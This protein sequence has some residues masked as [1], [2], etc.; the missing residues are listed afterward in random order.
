MDIPPDLRDACRALGQSRPTLWPQDPCSRAQRQAL[1]RCLIDQVVLD[2]RAPETMATRMVW[3]GGAV[4][5]LG[6]PCPVGRL[7][8]WRDVRQLEAQMLRR[9]SQGKADEESA[10]RLT[11]KGLR[12]SQPPERLASTVQLMRLRPGRRHRSWGPRPRRGAGSLTMPPIA[13]AVG[14]TAHGISPLIRCGRIGVQRDEETGLSL[15]PDRPETLEAFRPLRR[16]P[17]HRAQGGR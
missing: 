4:S 8:D 14:V 15:L 11:A 5:A 7:V 16:W 9:E 3:R 10:Q 6:G 12:S 2:R 13:T 1:R 17:A